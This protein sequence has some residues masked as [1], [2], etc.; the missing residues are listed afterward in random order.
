MDYFEPSATEWEEDLRQIRFRLIGAGLLLV[1]VTLIGTVGFKLIDPT[2]GWVRAF[3]M[4]AITLTTVGFGEEVPVDTDGARVFTAVL[5]LVGMGVLLYFVSTGTA[6]ILEGQ[7]SHVFR[8]R[9]MQRDLAELSSHIVVCGSGQAALYAAREL[10]AVQRPVVLVVTTP[11]AAGRASKELGELPVVLGNPTDESTLLAAGIDRAAGLVAC[12]DSDNENVVV[13]LTAR[14]VNPE[15]R[16]VSQVED[17]DHE[18]KIRKVGAN[19][20]VSPHFIG[21]LRMASELI[22]PTVVSFLDAMLRDRE[23]NLRVD[24]IRIPDGSPTVGKPLRDL[25]LERL[26]GILLVA[27]RSPSGQW[28]Y[29]PPRT[30]TVVAGSVLIFMGS[31]HESRQLCEQLGGEMIA[32]P[33]AG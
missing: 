14:Q 33:A 21:G 22:R 1:A 30:D 12:T 23:L 18:A 7:L 15:V 13:T 2:A 28:K 27:T 29:N 32:L 26:P 11:E 24:E 17:V 25:G 16:I 9:R 6:F 3:F 5:I 20:V 10:A 4:T 31:P 19:A 8:R